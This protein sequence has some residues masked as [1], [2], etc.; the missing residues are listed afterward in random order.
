M[1]TVFVRKIGS[2][3]PQA[4]QINCNFRISLQIQK[5]KLSLQRNQ[6]IHEKNKSLKFCATIFFKQDIT[7]SMLI[8]NPG[9]IGVVFTRRH[10][11]GME[12]SS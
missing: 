8:T 9:I 10:G 11:T 12:E 3:L 2:V 4:P 6:L 7:F 1:F 5:S